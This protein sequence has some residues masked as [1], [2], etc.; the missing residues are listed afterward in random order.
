MKRLLV[1]VLPLPNETP[2]QNLEW[3]PVVIDLLRA[4]T[5][6]VTALYHG[7][8]GIFPVTTIEQARQQVEQDGLLAGER[9][10]L[11]P[12]GFHFGNSPLE[13]IEKGVR[14][15]RLWFT[16]SNGTRALAASRRYGLP[17]VVSMLNLE[18]TVSCLVRRGKPVLLVCSG[19][20][21]SESR[22]DTFLAGAVALALS[23][24]E[25]NAYR[26]S[27]RAET[28]VDLY[29][30]GKD[31]VT[32]FLLKCPHGEKLVRIG[33]EDDVKYAAQEN[34]CPV[35]VCQQSDGWLRPQSLT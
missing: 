18:S 5:T 4:T 10:G 7:A 8:A 32:A 30:E 26:L 24:H 3:S 2:P 29:L 12:E 21:G 27:K 19:N 25:S 6:I 17:L 28:A 33:M 14:G 34:V 9:G 13:M 1:D 35:V 16:T 15:R 11:P 22:E 20:S 31:D 23:Q